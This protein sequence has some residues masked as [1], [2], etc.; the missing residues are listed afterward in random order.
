M[1]NSKQKSIPFPHNNNNPKSNAQ[2]FKEM[3]KSYVRI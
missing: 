2:V 1:I 3:M